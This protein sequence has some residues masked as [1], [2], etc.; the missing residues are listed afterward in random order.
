MSTDSTGHKVCREFIEN[1]IKDS[2]GTEGA[3]LE[4]IDIF[5]TLEAS[6]AASITAL[7]RDGT[8]LI[9]KYEVP[10]IVILPLSRL[11]VATKR[12]QQVNGKYVVEKMPA[13]YSDGSTHGIFKKGPHF[14]TKFYLS[15]ISTQD[16]DNENKFMLCNPTH[17]KGKKLV[18]FLINIF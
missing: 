10:R 5:A 17:A 18:I 13:L 7:H 14:F 16:F 6:D 1:S 8:T 3:H 15:D 11:K 2:I 12:F 4:D 9:L